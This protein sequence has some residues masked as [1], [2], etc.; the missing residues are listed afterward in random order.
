MKKQHEKHKK[1]A[2]R[3][4]LTLEEM[5][6]ARRW[7]QESTLMDDAT[8]MMAVE[9]DLEAATAMLKPLLPE[10]DF[11]L[12]EVKVQFT[13]PPSQAD[14]RRV[15]FDALALDQNGNSFDIEV[16]KADKN[17]SVERMVYYTCSLVHANALKRKDDY[18]KFR[19]VVVVFFCDGDF[20][21][22]KVPVSRIVPGL[23][24]NDQ[25]TETYE[26]MMLILIANIQS[27]EAN[28]ELAKLYDDMK[29]ANPGKMNASALANALGRVKNKDM[30]EITLQWVIDHMSKDEY[31]KYKQD[32]AEAERRG[33]ERM[34]TKMLAQ[35][36]VSREAA[37]SILGTDE[38]G[39][40]RLLAEYRS[41]LPEG[42]S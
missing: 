3:K 16:Q 33:A 19:R 38:A 14:G 17:F 21:S 5:E 1:G 23:T 32:I 29:Q 6:R 2:V 18:E 37:I 22:T 36:L 8:M 26:D 28:G 13:I 10:E 34:L 24:A 40:E 35:G 27:G 11:T 9:G 30:D 7:V 4:H 20:L 41:D 31:A 25:I 42:E 15:I 39:L 12:K